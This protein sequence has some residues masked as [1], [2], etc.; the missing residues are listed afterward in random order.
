MSTL[1]EQ[2]KKSKIEAMKAKDKIRNEVL[3]MMVSEIRKF[4][5]DNRTN[6]IDVSATDE[7]TI[8]IISKIAAKLKE[9][10]IAFTKGN[11]MDLVEKEE[12]QLKVISEFLPAAY[13]EEEIMIIINEVISKSEVKSLKSIMPEL[14]S[15]FNGKAD[16]KLVSSIVLKLIN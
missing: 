11:R 1:Q 2:I 4:E 9:S 3:S 8:S 5:I 12:Y 15:K 7:D 14:K 6:G 13:T 10:I 16:M